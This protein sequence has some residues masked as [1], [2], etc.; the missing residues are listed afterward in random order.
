[1][2]VAGGLSKTHQQGIVHRDIKP[3]NIM[4]TSDGFVKIVDFGLAKL[5]G[6]A[7]LTKTGTTMGTP[8]YMSPE[9][10]KGQ[11]VDHR[12]DIWALGV[13][14]YEMVT[15]ELPFKG[16]HEM[17][18]LYN[19]V[20]AEPAPVAKLNPKTPASLSQIIAKALN[21]EAEQRY[22]SMNDM[23]KELSA[24][25][26][27][28]LAGA[29]ASDETVLLETVPSFSQPTATGAATKIS[30]AEPQK[31]TV[32]KTKLVSPEAPP[33]KSSTKMLAAAAAILV[34]AA[35]SWFGY[36]QLKPKFGFVRIDS[37]PSGAAITLDN[38]LTAQTTPALLG[39]LK[40]G[41]HRV[42]LTRA[43]YETVSAS[44]NLSSG[45]TLSKIFELAALKPPTGNLSI[46]SQ[47]AGAK[48]V[49]NDK[50]V[51]QTTPADFRDL[52][53]G[54]YRVLINKEGFQP[55][56]KII[57]L[58]EGGNE[59]VDLVLAPAAIEV[60]ESRPPKTPR[61]TSSETKKEPPVTESPKTDQPATL[62]V[63][64]VLV[65]NGNETLI[66]AEIFVDGKAVGQAPIPL[67]LKSGAHTINARMLPHLLKNG[68]QAVT[69]QPG[70]KR[71]LQF[72]FEKL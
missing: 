41:Q 67:Q 3:A 51:E 27:Q 37:N 42:A 21:K 59:T 70:E 14:L 11:A 34:L 29:A 48:I 32:T 72:V 53:I 38:Q 49:I 57:H 46:K 47:P 4:I 63:T 12:T 52:E 33:K 23:L 2:Q 66:A 45:D 19:I 25:R 56:E 1:M 18:V 60:T 71:K 24:V 8:G 15:G 22:G 13:I 69:L 9:Q 44:F 5:S 20:N 16:E 58:T 40:S 61:Q 50:E 26:T 6:G 31:H 55:A 10:V 28:L 54:E 65:E 43:G 68:P 35:A 36:N 62:T 17:A 30:V 64:A 7:K 39:P